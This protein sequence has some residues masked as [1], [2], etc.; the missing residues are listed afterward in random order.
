M[1][2]APAQEPVI[3]RRVLIPAGVVLTVAFVCA[4]VV[5]VFREALHRGLAWYGASVG[6]ADARAAIALSV[7]TT[8]IVVIANATFGLAAAWA[9]GKHRIHGGRLL[10]MLITLPLAVSPVVGGMLVV[11]LVGARGWFGPWLASH[12][13][14]IMFTPA[15]IVLATVFTTLPLVAREVI[16][17]AEH[18]GSEPEEAAATLGAGGWHTFTRVT[19]PG[20]RGALV[21]GT[22]L[23]TA[24]ALGE[25]GAVSVVSG[26]IR[27]LTTT[28]PLHVEMR[29]DDYDFAG[30]FA[31]ASL[32]TAVALI[33][34]AVQAY[35]QWRD[36]SARSGP[37]NRR[38]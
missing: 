16:T 25:F 9:V 33:A 28:M 38:S 17:L 21:H 30:A 7:R 10:Q 13:Y 14:H 37:R 27:G 12:G 6:D 1:T 4:P 24:R 18:Q 36:P 29:Y 5:V 3:V 32:L 8:V 11:L 20:I 2:R 34:L 19:I 26:H 31:V 15:A 35:V 22:L 23:C